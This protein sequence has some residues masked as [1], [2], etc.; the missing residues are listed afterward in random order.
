[1]FS[2]NDS[3]HP[4]DQWINLFPS[5]IHHEP[6]WNTIRA[7]RGKSQKKNLSEK[8]IFN[9]DSLENSSLL[10]RMSKWHSLEI[11]RG[12]VNT[13]SWD[14]T[15]QYLLSGSDD[16]RLIITEPHSKKIYIGKNITETSVSS[17]HLSHIWF[18]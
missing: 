17:R 16:H 2:K 15:G 18:N 5:P 1:M 11:H 12:C 10:Q 13:I 9:H 7:A 4:V 3:G 8:S 14:E 6:K